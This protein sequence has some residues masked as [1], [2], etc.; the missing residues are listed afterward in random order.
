MKR[1]LKPI[2]AIIIFVLM[3]AL[4]GV[5]AQICQIVGL[6]EYSERLKDDD[7]TV[8]SYEKFLT[9]D[10]I[11]LA[12]IISGVLTVL[13]LYLFKMVRKKTMFDFGTIKWRY[14]AIGL[15]AAFAG[16]FA[17]DMLSEWIDLQNLMED[18][19]LDMSATLIG[20]IAIG[21]VGPIVEECVFR[22]AVIGNLVRKGEK[23]WIAI[24][25]SSI[26]FGFIH[27]NPAQI[28]FAMI[29]GIILGI[30]YVKTGNIVL[31]SIIHV[32]NNSFAVLQ[33]NMY[34]DAAKDFSYRNLLGSFD[35]PMIIILSCIS[36]FLLYKFSK[37]YDHNTL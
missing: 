15:I 30:I 9:G 28:P 33:M 3:Q 13:C 14:A 7:I 31:T 37:C 16:I 27:A 8:Q 24:L 36:V 2:L 12:L 23:P 34:G 6:F 35:I 18:Q 25:F 21:I 20:F 5:I 26:C 10:L 1:Y 11:S 32:I 17:S 19:F 29:V 22:E 4:V